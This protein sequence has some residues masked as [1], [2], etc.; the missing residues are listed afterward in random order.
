M[1]VRESRPPSAANGRIKFP[2]DEN[3]GGPVCSDYLG[4]HNAN[5]G[6]DDGRVRPN[7]RDSPIVALKISLLLPL[8]LTGRYDH[9]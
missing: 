2:G 5:R 8:R 6:R 4:Q 3:L 7:A 9:P 1:G